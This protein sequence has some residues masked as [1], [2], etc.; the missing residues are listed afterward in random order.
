MQHC[1]HCMGS[2]RIEIDYVTM[3]TSTKMH[4]MK[5]PL[6]LECYFLMLNIFNSVSQIGNL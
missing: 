4:Y 6:R 5:H 2:I 1:V 3:G